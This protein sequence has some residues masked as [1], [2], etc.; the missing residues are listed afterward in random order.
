MIELLKDIFANPVSDLIA[1]AA[2]S[3][4]AYAFV[5]KEKKLFIAP[6]WN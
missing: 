1:F 2:G 3:I 6:N 4:F 5:K